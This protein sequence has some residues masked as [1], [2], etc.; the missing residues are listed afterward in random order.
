ML[1]AAQI[2]NLIHEELV[3]SEERKA[4]VWQKSMQPDATAEDEFFRHVYIGRTHALEELLE[5]IE[6]MEKNG[7]GK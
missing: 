1:T 6:E 4:E 3:A 7:Q 5:L 2:K